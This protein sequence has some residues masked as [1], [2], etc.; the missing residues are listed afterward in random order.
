MVEARLDHPDGRVAYQ[1]DV[2]LERGGIVGNYTL[3]FWWDPSVMHPVEPG[4]H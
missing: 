4:E 3:A 2:Q 1:V